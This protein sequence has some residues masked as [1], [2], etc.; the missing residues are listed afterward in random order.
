MRKLLAVLAILVIFLPGSV[1]M[2][3]TK[4]MPTILVSPKGLVH[5][6]WLTVRAGADEAGEEFNAR[7]IWKGPALETDVAGQISIVEEY[8]NK[9]VDAIVLA[10]CDS[11]ALI[12][13]IKGALDKKIPV[14][15]FDSGVDSDLPLCFVATDNILGATKGGEMLVKLI[16]GRGKVACIPIVPGA[17][18]SIMR[19]K[20]FKDAIARFPEVRLVAV[21][22]SQSEVAVAM[23]VTENIL[24]AHPDLDGIFAAN[25]PGA[26]GAAQVL[27]A[28]GLLGKVKLVGFDA[29]PNQIQMLQDGGVQA[30]VVQN[31]FAMGYL[32]VKA[33]LDALAGKK[34]EK[35][36]DTGVTVV[37]MENFNESRVQKLLFPL[38][39]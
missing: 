14:I 22:Y 39:G 11:K 13:V 27:K 17:A 23:Q 6:F 28:K 21:Q 31:P 8:I 29:S 32:G 2:G 9:K 19:E 15:T 24:V 37:T 35:R 5:S 36:I 38:G 30:L 1:L 4:R 12:P 25:E 7:I 3:A 18:T 26:I 34:V 10:A 16:G 20:G 33:A